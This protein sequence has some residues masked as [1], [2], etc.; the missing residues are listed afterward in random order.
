MPTI[1]APCTGAVK[2]AHAAELRAMQVARPEAAAYRLRDMWILAGY[3]SVRV[4][5]GGYVEVSDAGSVPLRDRRE[6]HRVIANAL[7]RGQH[8]TE[9]EEN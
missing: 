2:P 9:L 3:T 4:R 6:S 1:Y 5:I 7:R 8:F